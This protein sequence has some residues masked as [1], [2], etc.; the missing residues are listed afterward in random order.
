MKEVFLLFINTD[1]DERKKSYKIYLA[2]PNK[3]VIAILSESYDSYYNVKL[4]NLNELNFKL[5]YYTHSVDS[6][7]KNENIEKIKQ[8]MYLLI[9][10]NNSEEWMIIDELEDVGEKDERYLKVSS[11]TN[12]YE[13]SHKMINEMNL[14]VVN[15]AKYYKRILDDTSWSL[16]I[17][18]PVFKEVY[19][20]FE[21]SNSNVLEAIIEG[22]E[23]F[24]AVLDYDTENKKINLYDLD[25]RSKY[26]GL[27]INYRNF[28]QSVSKKSTVDEMTTRMYA[29]GAEGVN[30]SNVNPTG[31]NYIEDFSYFIHPFKRDSN[32]NVLKSSYYMSD[33]L[34]H[35]LLD[36]GELTEKHLPE[37][38]NLQ[39]QINIKI[40]TLV[41]EETELNSIKFELDTA[42]GLLDIAKAVE[43][44]EL[45]NKRRLEVAKS[46][47][48]FDN[49]SVVVGDIQREIDLLE[50]QKNSL[51][52]RIAVTSLS[53][54]LLD[55][56]N[57][58]IIEKEFRDDRY[59]DEKELFHDAK[60]KFKN[61]QKPD[62]KIE[63]SIDNILNS[64]E[65]EYY[66]DKLVIGDI[67]RITNKEMR[68][69]T[70]SIITE[71]RFDMDG[72]SHELVITND[73][74]NSDGFDKILTI[75]Y[76]TQSTTTQLANNKHKWDAVADVKNRVDIMRDSAIDA[77]KNR[78]YAGVNESI[79][80]S[81][82]G[83]V[84]T[85][86]DF[87]EEMVI[88]QAGVMALSKNSGEDWSTSITPD[89]VV[90]DTIIGKL[91]AGNNLIITNDSGSFEIDS[92]GLEIDMDSIKIMSGTGDKPENIIDSW[93]NILL[94]MDEFGDSNRL[95]MYEKNQ[96]EKQLEAITAT[97]SSMVKIAKEAYK[98]SD[99]LPAEYN[100]Y[101]EAYEA[102]K[103]YLTEEIQTD[104]HTIL[105]KKNREETTQIDGK[106]YS[107][108]IK[109]FEVKRSQFQTKIPLDFSQTYLEALN[110]SISLNY[111]SNGEIVTKL[112]VSKEGVRIDGKLL[113]IN[114]ETEFNDNLRMNAGLILS[115]NN[116]IMIDL[117]KG[118]INLGKP[119]KI[120]SRP[121]ATEDYADSV[122]VGV[123]NLILNSD[124]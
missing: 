108:L 28:L 99:P 106:K 78:I 119:L 100:I 35:G 79:E 44:I 46:K 13:N 98:P 39:G 8:K 45:V 120:N 73:N 67:A 27:K 121:V 59:I 64:V 122:E 96:I 85:N 17:V 14:E 42:R 89:G 2:K 74:S 19:R 84:I 114:S 29:Y 16:G 68:V 61:S 123:R 47:S 43:D 83:I 87:P 37:I 112:N 72:D 20:S 23:T 77:T 58:Y 86:P 104:G 103:N 4:G 52:D 54:D 94:T 26:K 55:E 41:K 21:I 31:L 105:D 69:D 3:E 118:E 1:K 63:T 53:V 115:K 56:L 75:L 92:S 102:L 71:L 116:D 22:A 30:I 10:Y 5:P 117:N 65:D 124:K 57:P 60:K 51:Q 90:A 107:R 11:F 33:E 18:D 40:D 101:I 24:G 66:D 38:N 113:E 81:E 36:L 7:D 25:S 34:C 48:L 76:D 62:L 93:N 95:N 80:I 91:I 70:K 12:A 109:D 50:L 15:P 110:D 6:L 111:V 32:K 97:H 49:Q 9:K 88:L 82:R